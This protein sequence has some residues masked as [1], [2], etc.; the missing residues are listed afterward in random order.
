MGK[1]TSI[2]LVGTVLGN[3]IA[4]LLNFLIARIFSSET[5]GQ[6]SVVIAVATLFIGVATM[7]LEIRSLSTKDEE[8]AKLL[9]NAGFGMAVWWAIGLSL[10]T[11]VAVLLG[12]PAFWLALGLMVLCGAMQS[13]GATALT[14]D[15]KYQRLSLV[16]M[17]QASSMGILQVSFGL[18]HAGVLALLAGFAAARAVWLPTLK[19]LRL[20]LNPIKLLSRT[21]RR[22]MLA[23]GSSA[24]INAAASQSSVILIGILFSSSDT[25]N[26]AMAQRIIAVPLGV[27]SQAVASA[28]NGEMSVLVRQK[29]DWLKEVNKTVRILL[30]LGLIICGGAFAFGIWLAPTFLGSEFEASGKFIAVL[31]IGSWLQFA[32]SPFSQLLNITNSHRELLVWDITRFVLLTLSLTIPSS[33]GASLLTTLL[34][35]SLAMT[36]VYVLL[37]LAIRRAWTRWNISTNTDQSK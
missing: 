12:A 29:G 26:Y 32:I 28:S 1:S 22:F 5:Y 20:P 14:R 4:W 18:I 35:Y 2:I 30:L 23:A 15:R 25:G 36:V 13:L 16:N 27:I 31:A 7:R 21:H 6:A 34:C 19:Q 17:A 11:V 24:L 37:Y 10:S 8:E 33:L 9:L 3:G